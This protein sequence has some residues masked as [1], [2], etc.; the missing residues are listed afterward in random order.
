MI[1]LFG[2][3]KREVAWSGERERRKA[4]LATALICLFKNNK[5]PTL[6]DMR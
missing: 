3:R 2:L 4:P 6:E 1:S 5:Y